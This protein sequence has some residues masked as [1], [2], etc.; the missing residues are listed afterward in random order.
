MFKHILLPTDGTELSERAV[1]AAIEFAR[2]VQC[3]RD[4][5]PRSVIARTIGARDEG[6]AEGSSG[7]RRRH[8]EGLW[9]AM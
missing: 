2:P 4:R 7:F 5:Y 8:G 1:L 3:P 9:S 6:A